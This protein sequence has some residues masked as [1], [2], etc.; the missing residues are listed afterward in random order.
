VGVQ[1]VLNVLMGRYKMI[2]SQV[3]DYCYGLYGTPPRPVDPEVRK[4]ALKDYPRGEEPITCRAA[5]V[6]EPEME[7]AKETTKDIA[8]DIGDVLTY[9]LYPQTGMRFLRWKYGLEDPPEEVKPKTMDQVKRD[10][11]LVKKALAGELVEKPAKEAPPRGPGVRT[12]NVFVDDAYYSVDVEAV[13]GAPVITEIT[14]IQKPAPAP[15][16]K[17]A[18]LPE[19]AAKKAEEAPAPVEEGEGVI[20]APMPGMIVEI[21]CD[22]GDTVAAGDEV[23]ILEAM[24]MQ[25]PLT[26]PIEGTVKAINVKAGDSVESGDVLIVI[27]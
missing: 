20:A 27:A 15:A 26:S 5:D 22:V 10:E 4:M 25:N 17:P 3:K 21:K 24:K 1:A 12:Y 14:P 9:A 18:P 16:A 23:L 11:D 19:P 2:T 6:L 7:E 13:G 8:K